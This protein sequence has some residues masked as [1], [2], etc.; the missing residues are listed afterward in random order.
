MCFPHCTTNFEFLVGLLVGIISSPSHTLGFTC[1]RDNGCCHHWQRLLYIVY[2]C[3]SVNPNIK[4]IKRSLFR[5]YPGSVKDSYSQ[6]SVNNTNHHRTT[7]HTPISG[8]E[9]R[10]IVFFDLGPVGLMPAK[11]LFFLPGS[12]SFNLDDGPWV[13]VKCDRVLVRRDCMCALARVRITGSCLIVCAV[14]TE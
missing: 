7:L 4:T 2:L 9:A 11:S 5:I 13:S 6:V 14:C 1:V 3:T 8:Y 10:W 12:G